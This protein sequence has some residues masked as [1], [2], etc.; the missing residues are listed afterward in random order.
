MKV[1]YERQMSNL[2]SVFTF[3]RYP[4]GQTDRQTEIQEE[5]GRNKDPRQK[6]NGKK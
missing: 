4:D 5:R 2:P 1:R 3:Y 6:E